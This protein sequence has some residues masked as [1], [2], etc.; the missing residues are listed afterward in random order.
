MIKVV[1]VDDE[2]II[3]TGISKIIDWHSAGC[4]L[5]AVFEN[6][7][8]AFD[9]LCSYP[10][11]IVITDIKMP[12]MDGIQLVKEAN[13]HQ[14]PVK[15]ILLSGY[16]E[17]EYAKAAMEYGVQHYILKPSDET[18][19]IQAL[20]S[21]IEKIQE[22]KQMLQ[23]LYTNERNMHKLLPT[24]KEGFLSNF[25]LQGACSDSDYDFFHQILMSQATDCRL[26]AFQLEKENT[27]L[28]QFALRNISQEIL[29]ED[30]SFC[31]AILYEQII[32]LTTLNPLNHLIEKIVLIKEKFESFFSI[33]LRAVITS[34]RTFRELP[35]LYDE[36]KESLVYYYYLP[37]DTIMTPDITQKLLIKHQ[38]DFQ[39]SKEK[40]KSCLSTGSFEDSVIYIDLFFQGLQNSMYRVEDMQNRIFD[41][42]LFLKSLSKNENK[43]LDYQKLR[44]LISLDTLSDARV[45]I[46][47]TLEQLAAE[48]QNFLQDHQKSI[49][50]T[51]MKLVDEHIS[52]PSLSLKWIART[53]LYMS[54]DYL[55]KLF[56][57]TAG[58]KFTKYLTEQKINFAKKYLEENPEIKVIELCDALG[59]ENNPTYLSTLFKNHTGMTLTD[60]RKQLRIPQ[61]CK[62]TQKYN[63]N[64]EIQDHDQ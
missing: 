62:L 39:F 27:Y 42:Y 34:S 13:Y 2:E 18:Q 22:E 28:S 30:A 54:E 38:G 29:R 43:I 6:G 55:S 17:F 53:K 50:E 31:F 41:L 32:L 25:I 36:A 61:H 48:N 21:L 1:L 8:Q 64:K 12:V 23:T 3:R 40:L 44:K 33:P 45:F 56:S 10:A 59:F 58:M 15:F 35:A 14:L 57:K 51:I 9:Y 20:N 16:G 46:L 52:N 4:E 11:D 19:I 60:Y 5:T 37:A 47:H 7:K 26:I 49:V 24:A 63:L